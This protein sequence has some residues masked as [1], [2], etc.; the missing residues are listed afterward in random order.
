MKYNKIQILPFHL[1]LPYVSSNVK[2]KVEYAHMESMPEHTNIFILRMTESYPGEMSLFTRANL[3]EFAQLCHRYLLMRQCHMLQFTP[4]YFFFDEPN[5]AKKHCSC[6]RALTRMLYKAFL[7][8]KF[9]F[10]L[11]YLF[12]RF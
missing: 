4:A 2:A 7:T 9:K 3:T 11:N 8:I 12:V 10:R 5:L 6:K 1:S